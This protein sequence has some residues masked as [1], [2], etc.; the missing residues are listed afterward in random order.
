MI[1][2]L[3]IG[4]G[5]HA[6]VVADILLRARDTGQPV[7]PIGYLDDDASLHGRLF[8]DLPVLRDIGALDG[9]PHD[10]IIIAIGNNRIRKR[11]ADAL[12][13]AGYCPSPRGRHRARC[14]DRPWRDDLCWRGGQ[15]RLSDRLTRHP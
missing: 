14:P 1:R 10:A 15:H 6:Q 7:T 9:I 4:A 3:I 2:V 8:L 11:L 5:G 12:S 13:V